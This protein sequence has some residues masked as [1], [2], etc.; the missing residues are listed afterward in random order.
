MEKERIELRK[1]DITKIDCG[2]IV[3][4]SNTSLVLGGGVSGAIANAAGPAIQKEMNAIGHCRV[5]QAVIT[6]AGDLPC[7]KVI[8]AVGPMMGEGNEDNKLKSATTES[9][10]R[11]EENALSCIAFPAVSAGIFGY[12]MDRCAAVMIGAVRDY[13][14]ANKSSSIEKVIFCLWGDEAYDIFKLILAR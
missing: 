5:G 1:G 10:K 9:L 8:H 13:F 4:P 3:N 11:A 12:P 2:A 7:E 14:R 6:G